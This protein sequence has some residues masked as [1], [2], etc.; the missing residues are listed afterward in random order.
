MTISKPKLC[1]RNLKT[2][3]AS[4]AT[5]LSTFSRHLASGSR[6]H[7]RLLQ[8]IE[9]IANES[10]CDEDSIDAPEVSL[11][12]LVNL[13]AIV[14]RMDRDLGPTYME[15]L[16]RGDCT[17]EIVAAFALQA[18]IPHR[19]NH[20]SAD[21][22]EVYDRCL[23]NGRRI[24]TEFLCDSLF[25]AGGML[26]PGGHAR[27]LLGGGAKQQAIK[28]AKTVKWSLKVNVRVKP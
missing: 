24:V 8:T 22:L 20:A 12:E 6:R 19:S 28:E 10:G 3:F 15:P 23:G 18:L 14:A 13:T 16:E 27:E 1:D 5:R 7:G 21:K 2:P 9:R 4:S 26:A 25:D 17:A 11:T